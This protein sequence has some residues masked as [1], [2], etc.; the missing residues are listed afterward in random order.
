MKELIY[1]DEPKILFGNGQKMEDPRDGLT[2]FGPIEN[3][4]PYGIINGVVGTK[5]G[6]K[7]FKN[8]VKYLQKPINNF[9]NN[10]RPF[11]P[12]F[13]A[14]FRT[15]WEADKTVFKEITDSDIG[16]HLFHEDTHTRTYN[17]VSLFTEKI[18][19]AVEDEDARADVWFVIIPEEI[20]KYC[21]PKSSLPS[22]LVQIKRT[23]KKTAAKK[24]IKT[25]MESLFGEINV[26]NEPFKHDAHFHH[27]LKARLLHKAIPTQILR[28]ST[29]DW[30]NYKKSNDA[31]LRDFSKIE[32]HLAWSLSTAAFYKTGGRPWKL[33]DIRDGVCY[34]GLVYKKD[35]RSGDTRNACCA[36]QMFLDSGDGTVFR[37]AVG[38]WYNDKTKEFHLRRRQAKELINIAVETYKEKKGGYPKELFIHARTRFNWEEWR[39]FSDAVPD[40]TNLVG[41]SISDKKPLKIYRPDS[42][43]PMLRGL[44]YIQS[45]KSGFLWS[46]GYV[47]RLETSLAM[48]VPNPLFIEISKGQSDI[49]TVM[50]DILALTKLNYNACIY[51]D[52]IPVTLRFADS[53][54]EILT[55]SPLSNTPPLAFKYY[56]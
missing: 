51:G 5:D 1:L 9:N 16:K 53:I 19:S 33:A 54:G 3:N 11:Y 38:P 35:E 24:M 55:A 52:G 14:V 41:I 25:G 43:F 29:I 32:G 44:A 45:D 15:K 26:E 12:G 50:Q 40:S 8:F 39:G 10:T 28:E 18:I 36:A 21:R 6:L 46:K 20:Y 31:Y 56:I 13:E 2:L 49:K 23:T 42:N 47:P 7:K 34:V 30:K 37:G 22:E 48:E 17:L 27:Q 4:L